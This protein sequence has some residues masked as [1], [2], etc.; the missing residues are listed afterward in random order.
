M[1]INAEVDFVISAEDMKLLKNLERISNYGDAGIFP[2]YGGK[3]K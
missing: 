3:L 2:V 1:K